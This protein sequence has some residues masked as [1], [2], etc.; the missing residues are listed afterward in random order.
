MEVGFIGGELGVFD[1]Y[2][3]EV[4]YVDVIIWVMVLW[5]FL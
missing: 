1:F 3:V 4:M 5:V 2:V